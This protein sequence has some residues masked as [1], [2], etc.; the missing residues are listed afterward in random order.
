MENDFL[1]GN[2][3]IRSWFVGRM[4]DAFIAADDSH[5]FLDANEHA[6]MLFPKLN[7][8]EPSD[9][10]PEDMWPLFSDEEN[11]I[12][13]KNRYYEKRLIK[14]GDM[15][16]VTC[17]ILTDRTEQES[18]IRELEK[19]RED[20]E[21]IGMTKSLFLSNVSHEIRTPMN[22]IV[23]MSDLLLRE[24]VSLKARGY[25]DNIKVSVDNLLYTVNEL[26][27]IS[28]IED[29]SLKIVEEAYEPMSL[30]NDLSMIFIHNIGD[31]PVELL[32]SIDRNMPS[33]LYGDVKRIKQIIINIVNNAI[34]YTD[35][36][37]IRLSVDI[38]ERYDD[39]C[40]LSFSIS[41]SGQGIRDEDKGAL[42]YPFRRHDRESEDERDGPGLGL[43]VCRQLVKLM[44]G[45][46]GVESTFGTGSCFFF[47]L[48]QGIVDDRDAA[49]I[50]EKD[51]KI[52][53]W[54]LIENDLLKESL[55]DLCGQY[56]VEVEDYNRD[57][58]EY[59]EKD[60][61]HIFL[62]TDNSAMLE[63][64]EEKGL[65]AAGVKICVLR[66]PVSGD[67]VDEKGR[68][69]VNKPLYSLNFCQVLNYGAS[70]EKGGEGERDFTAP[71]ARI[72]I[73][74]DN[75]M[76]IQV[77]RELLSP[78]KMHID[79]A[80]NGK[81]GVECVLGNNYDLIFMDHMMPV[82]DGVQAL[83]RIR[84]INDGIY[85]GI[86]VVA[87]SANATEEAEELFREKGFSDFVEKPIRVR[88]LI[89]CV[90]KWL[91]DEKIV[92]NKA[93]EDFGSGNRESEAET[94]SEAAILRDGIPE[95][96][97]GI[98]VED[99]I[100]YCG[101]PA[102][103]LKCLVIFYKIIDKK[104]KVISKCLEDDLV[105]DLTIEVHA[106][107]NSARMI[108]AGKLSED[109]KEL[110]R[111]GNEEDL[112]GLKEKTPEVLELYQSYKA[113][114]KPFSEKDNKNASIPEKDKFIS[115]L[116]LIKKAIDEFDM[117]GADEAMSKI[118]NYPLPGDLNEGIMELD[119]LVSDFAME[120]VV[121][122]ADD[123]IMRA[124]AIEDWSL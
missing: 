22:A 121:A 57:M 65:E 38:E 58:A 60:Y 12:R 101:S 59:A 23:G 117:D 1:K 66:N 81:A 31:K 34:Q 73:V 76:N 56:S 9:I 52:K 51:R 111:M 29:G 39:D 90:R 110:E 61:G 113:V 55:Y 116:E 37:F 2:N 74:D 27:D 40:I 94:G 8:L 35:S 49:A 107:K 43:S 109:F 75:E 15:R 78:L 42:F 80:E 18:V 54:S 112:A 63:S 92:E 105:R 19:I 99:G 88:E 122:L 102:L 82:M 41:D 96:I 77:A 46:I 48:S 36:G 124:K 83:E 119:A 93:G 91:P 71:D 85:A 21:V 32:Y 100:N 7:G 72:L 33:R 26:F 97:E 6:K 95:T 87:L 30:F 3:N 70:V 20:K 45:E 10:L 118:R 79:S 62:F 104:T 67:P 11:R 17:L 114:L 25:I 14:A 44:G 84:E 47:K 98:N 50:K 120:D 69:L 5:V 86:P 13:L 115:E 106:L 108:G 53:V 24:N 103:F 64:Y 4:E 68:I 89:K 123:L 28:R 16:S